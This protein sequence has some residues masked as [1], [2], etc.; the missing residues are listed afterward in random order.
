MRYNLSLAYIGAEEF[1]AA[2]EALS[3]LIK[4]DNTYWVAYQKLAEVLIAQE[5]K[6]AAR[7]ILDRLLQQKPDY[8]N[9]DQVEQMLAN[10]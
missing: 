3:E 1:T 4:I 6:D 9:R 7:D 5:E 10:M 8:E 2:E